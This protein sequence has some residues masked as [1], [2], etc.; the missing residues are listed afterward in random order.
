MTVQGVTRENVYLNNYN[1]GGTLRGDRNQIAVDYW[2]PENPTGNFP[3]PTEGNDP[4][5]ATTIGFQ[6]AS[7]V[8]LQNVTLGYTLP[9]TFASKINLSKARVYVT[10]N[11]LITKTEYLSYSP[12]VNPESYPEAAVVVMGLQIDF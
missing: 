1:N 12:E 6:D 4:D 2:L 9:D 3:R 10:G 5:F 7:Y 8:R 11:N